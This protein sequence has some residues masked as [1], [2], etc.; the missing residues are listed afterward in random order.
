MSVVATSHERISS[1]KRKLSQKSMTDWI[2]YK[3]QWGMKI[4]AMEGS[5]SWI[6]KGITFIKPFIKPKKKR[7]VSSVTQWHLDLFIHPCSYPELLYWLLWMTENQKYTLFLLKLV[8]S[9]VFITVIET[10]N[11]ISC[12]LIVGVLTIQDNSIWNLPF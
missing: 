8:W 5:K 11:R 4:Q 6:V 3:D 1:E 10:I 2:L 7:Q 9:W 12:V